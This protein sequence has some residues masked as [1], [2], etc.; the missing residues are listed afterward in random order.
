MAPRSTEQCENHEVVKS[1][2]G[3]KVTRNPY[4]KELTTDNGDDPNEVLR[5]SIKNVIIYFLQKPVITGTLLVLSI[6]YDHRH[7]LAASGGRVGGSAFSSFSSPS[8]SSSSSSYSSSDSYSSSSYPSYSESDS[9]TYKTRIIS[10][11]YESYTTQVGIPV[12]P[13]SAAT[14]ISSFDCFIDVIVPMT[15]FAICLVM[16]IGYISG[17]SDSDTVKGTS[18]TSLLKLQVGLLGTGRSLQKDLNRLAESADT[19]TS[20]GLSF[21]L[22]E[23]VLYWLQRHPDYY[24]SAYSFVD[25]KK[26]VEECEKGFNEICIEERG[27]LDEKTLVNVNNIRRKSKNNAAT[28]ASNGLRNEFI[29]V[30]IIVAASGLHKLSPIKNSA[31]LKKALHILASI[32]SSKIMAAEVIWTPEKEDDTFSEQ[33]L[34]QDY[35]L[36]CLL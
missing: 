9:Y 2:V 32:P 6:S 21:V 12:C 13:N 34:L 4:L 29:V 5:R 19:S 33:Q 14:K 3:D 16:V 26:G 20:Q 25:I 35:P 30:T 31:Q 10:P 23:M 36:M 7:A 22:Q 15:F 27:K 17:S 24:I 8:S 28:Q 11:S 1:I 18:K